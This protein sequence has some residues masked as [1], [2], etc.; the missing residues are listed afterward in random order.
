MSPSKPASGDHDTA[1]VIFT[2]AANSHA[3]YNYPE[4]INAYKEAVRLD[5]AYYEAWYNLGL[6]AY[7]ANDLP[8]ALL[9]GE[10]ALA[11]NP[12][13]TA[14]RY[15]FALALQR[16]NYPADAAGQ[17]EKLL[18]STPNEARAH[19]TLANLY[20]R[21]LGQP[22]R[23]RSHYLRVLALDPRH[24]QATQIRYWLVANP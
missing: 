1:K 24:P 9:A 3:R 15:N 16:A 14:A 6:A 4:A 7:E 2:R 18:G 5:P 21:D 12:E 23:A 19:L 8:S 13:A 11:I 20:A 10:Q 22:A 17:L